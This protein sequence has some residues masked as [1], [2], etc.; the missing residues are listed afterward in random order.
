M[1]VRDIIWG[2]SI[3]GGLPLRPGKQ[4]VPVVGSLCRREAAAS[5]HRQGRSRVKIELV[6]AVFASRRHDHLRQAMIGPPPAIP[7]PVEA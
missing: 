6:H 1:P 5:S 3:P 7:I 2:L 4:G